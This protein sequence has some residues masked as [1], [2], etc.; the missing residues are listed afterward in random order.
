[1]VELREGASVVVRFGSL[2]E[3]WGVI[4]VCGGVLGDVLGVVVHLEITEA[5]GD[6]LI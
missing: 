6:C 4:M 1:M 2:V 5:T 3:G